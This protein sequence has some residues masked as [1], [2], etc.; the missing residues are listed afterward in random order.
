MSLQTIIINSPLET[1]AKDALLKRLE[2]EGATEAVLADIKASLQ[3]FID[4]GFKEL[5]V[6]ADMNDP[7]AKAIQAEFDEQVAQA[8]TEYA[9][10]LENLNIDAA[11]AQAKANRALDVV[12]VNAMKAGLAA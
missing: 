3:E 9:E 6:T 7:R 2:A 12:Q 10:E 8:Q 4:S 1:K 11:V 5:G